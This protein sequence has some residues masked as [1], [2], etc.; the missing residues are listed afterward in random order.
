MQHE[1]MDGVMNGIQKIILIVNIEILL[2]IEHN[3]IE[4]YYL[5]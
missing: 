4:Y 1:I 3:I 5:I 2:K